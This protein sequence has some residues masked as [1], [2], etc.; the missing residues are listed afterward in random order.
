MPQEV[1]LLTLLLITAVNV[2]LPCNSGGCPQDYVCNKSTDT[3]EVVRECKD[4]LPW[5]ERNKER[6]NGQFRGFLEQQC[7]KTCG[8]C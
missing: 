7:A 4:N 1:L 3:C 6:C 5:C 8:Y 2:Q